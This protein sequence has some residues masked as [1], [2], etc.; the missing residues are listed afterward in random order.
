[1]EEAR[2]RERER[3][4]VFGTAEGFERRE[5]NESISQSTTNASLS[6]RIGA[7]CVI[8]LE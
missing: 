2:E 4:Y 1:L 6:N 3:E 7:V 5:G 8:N